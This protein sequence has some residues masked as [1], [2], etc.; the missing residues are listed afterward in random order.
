VAISPC[1][2]VDIADMGFDNFLGE[3]GD[4]HKYLAGYDN[5]EH[6]FTHI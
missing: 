4:F 6:D 2:K 5:N 3:A 1:K